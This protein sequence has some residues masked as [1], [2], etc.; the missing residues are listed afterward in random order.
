MP[1]KDP[2]VRRE[3]QRGYS[4]KH[5]EKN[6]ERAKERTLRNKRLRRKEW[7]AFKATLSCA[8]CGIRNPILI[9]FHHVDKNNK[10]TVNVLIKNGRFLRAFEEVK[11]CIPLC[12]NCHRLVHQRERHK[13]RKKRKY[14]LLHTR[15]DSDT[16]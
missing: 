4:K 10:E 9:D 5:Y 12:A 11:K 13:A 2:D 1:Y 16:G 15:R 7:D 3:K 8:H 14:E 6:K